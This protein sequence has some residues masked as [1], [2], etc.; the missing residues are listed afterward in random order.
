MSKLPQRIKVNQDPYTPV[1]PRRPRAP[2]TSVVSTPISNGRQSFLQPPSQIARTRSTSLPSLAAAQLGTQSRIP[3]SP[4]ITGAPRAPRVTQASTSPTLIP[5]TP[6]S[7]TKKQ[8]PRISASVSTSYHDQLRA[9]PR[10]YIKPEPDFLLRRLSEHLG[11]AFPAMRAFLPID[12]L[13]ALHE[14]E[15]MER[16]ERGARRKNSIEDMNNIFGAPL[17]QVSA[18]ASTTAVVGGLQHTLPIVVYACVEQLYRALQYPPGPS[19]PVSRLSSLVKRFDTPPDFGCTTSLFQESESD[20]YSVLHLFL[21]SLPEPIVFPEGI[22]EALVPFCLQS[23]DI[24]AVQLLLRFLTS[25]NLSLFVY[26]LAFLSQVTRMRPGIELQLGK[27]YGHCV[28]GHVHGPSMLSWFLSNWGAIVKGLFD[29]TRDNFSLPSSPISPIRTANARTSIPLLPSPHENISSGSDRASLS[30]KS[31]AASLCTTS[32]MSHDDR[33]LDEILPEPSPSPR[34]RVVN[35]DPSCISDDSETSDNPPA[36]DFERA[37]GNSHS[38]QFMA[39]EKRLK[40]TGALKTV[41]DSEKHDASSIYSGSISL[42]SGL[43]SVRSEHGSVRSAGGVKVDNEA[44]TGISGCSP[45]CKLVEKVRTLEAQ[46]LAMVQERD[47]ARAVVEDIRSVMQ[48]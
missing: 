13:M 5:I 14:R 8:F 7:P 40:V 16:Q 47:E 28:F 35:R 20:I 1:S 45:T 4:G 11:P 29:S 31:D 36:D 3:R 12:D 39:L 21:T 48:L 26:L 30:D 33:I 22:G 15:W 46:L 32:T 25:A 37:M 10:R 38:I 2:S 43:G 27:D 19:P 41:G 23:P 34:L 24:T 9:G 17:R 18:Y 44:E 42:H 6:L